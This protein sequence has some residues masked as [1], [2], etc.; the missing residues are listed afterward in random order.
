MAGG[1]RLA[2]GYIQISAETSAVPQQIKDALDKAGTAAAK[3]AGQQMGK[4][5]SQG[6]QDGLRTAPTASGGNASVIS[7]VIQ[8]KPIGGNVRVQAQK[9]GK[10]LG[11]G[12][13]QGINDAVKS[14]TGPK[15]DEI[16]TKAAKPKE[17]GDK[18]GKELNEGVGGAL[19]DLGK[20]ALEE[21]KQGAKQWGTGV[22]DELRKGD[23]KGAFGDVGDVVENTTSMLNTLSKTVGVNLDSVEN[24]GRDAA[25][26]L[27]KVG[28][29]IQTWVDRVKGGAS[30]VKTFADTVKGI[31][32]G[33]AA[34]RL[35]ATGRALGLLA[36][37]TKKLTGTD[38]SGF[39]RPL[40]DITD[41]ASGVASVAASLKEIKGLGGVGGAAGAAEKFGL[42][43]LGAGGFGL[44]AVGGVAAL[45]A[46]VIAVLQSIPAEKYG[47]L[48][49]GRAAKPAEVDTG[50]PPPTQPQ[51]AAAAAAVPPTPGLPPEGTSWQLI[52]G[53]W[54]AVPMVGN[55][56]SAA[57]PGYAPPGAPGIPAAPPGLPADDQ[58]ALDALN[59]NRAKRGLPP[60][61]AGGVPPPPP[62][63]PRAAPGLPPVIAD[64]GAPRVPSFAETI[65]AAHGAAVA[66]IQAG[67]ANVSA[68]TASVTAGSVNVSGAAAA[69]AASPAYSQGKSTWW[70]KQTGG[71]IGGSG[72]VPI[73]AHGG[74]HVLT[75]DDVQAA[76]GQEAVSAWRNALH[77]D[78]GGEV[79]NQ[80]W[81]KDAA[82]KAGM[83]PDQYVAAM[84]HTPPAQPG[85]AGPGNMPLD[86][87]QADMHQNLL[88]Q[89]TDQAGQNIAAL[90]GSDRT[91][92]FVPVGAGSK[93]VAG[94]SFVSGLLNL[95]N[96]AVGGLIDTGAEAAQAAAAVGGFGAGG[97][98]AG[99]AIQLGASEAKR[100][101]S[102]GFQMAGILADAGIEQLFGVFGGAPRWL[103]YDYT[104]FIPNINTGDIGTTTLEKAMGAS[105]DGKQAPGQQPGGPVTPEH[106]PGEQ[107]VGPPVPKFGDPSAQQPALGGLAQTGQGAQAGDI[108]AGL[109]AGLAAGGVGAPPPAPGSASPA[110]APPPPGGGGNLL[111]GLI[112]GFGMDEGGMLPHNS[113]A[114]NTSGRPELVLSPQQLDAMGT[115]GNRN[116]YSRGG[117]TINITAVDAQDVAAQIDKRK[118]L[119][120]MQYN[121][122]P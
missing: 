10:E 69:V 34:S 94:T 17:I 19:K 105:K 116:P 62:S 68:S 103:G 30:D 46:I 99:P 59:A 32:S 29:G 108:K 115:S 74:E 15:I 47:E 100:A 91:G 120:A 7:D 25:T 92:G 24:F 81:L 64:W 90:S 37:N 3:P 63:P 23:V 53:K 111:Q 107:P 118:R 55:V 88:G 58:A 57:T 11:T 87:Q 109:A 35:D 114:I 43:G 38:I 76:G 119:A 79:K 70:S 122:R 44:G 113:M 51:M 2:V 13:N 16:I 65:G 106:L 101:V 93:A 18:I 42:A 71:G 40:Q 84:A 54:V 48:I 6:I 67:Q 73:I 36:D 26:T 96:E 52:N 22:A 112:P 12:I 31:G 45:G 41:S 21:L 39:T 83:T 4:D 72:P 28:G 75:A 95:G 14:G 9:V 61:S 89:G 121:S 49:R 86:Q 33:D 117:D 97:A 56:P 85:M 78:D 102:Y 50:P 98:A 66:T 82:Q 1:V 104:Q 20:G 8:G 5:I 77:Y 27:D 110:P 80:Q 60:V